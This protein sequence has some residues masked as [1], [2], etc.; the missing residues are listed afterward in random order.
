MN[1]ELKELKV[2]KQKK[3]SIYCPTCGWEGCI[4]EIKH[5]SVLQS[6]TETFCFKCG[7]DFLVYSKF[8][9]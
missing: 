4:S 1:I 6:I 5:G 2:S 9:L 8:K 3:V 7:N